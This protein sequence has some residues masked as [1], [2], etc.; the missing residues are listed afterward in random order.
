MGFRP[1][2]PPPKTKY[3]PDYLARLS[4]PY[5]PHAGTALFTVGM[6]VPAPAP[7]PAAATAAVAAIASPAF[8]SLTVEWQG[9][10]LGPGVPYPIARLTLPRAAPVDGPAP[11]GLART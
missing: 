8:K 2:P 4:G 11:S 7:A 6:R 10:P 9:T 5:M 1:F 3:N